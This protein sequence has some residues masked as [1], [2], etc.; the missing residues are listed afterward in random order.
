MRKFRL[1]IYIGMAFSLTGL[2]APIAQSHPVAASAPST[3]VSDRASAP[4]VLALALDVMGGP[5]VVERVSVIKTE[6]SRLTYHLADSEHSL[7]PYIPDYGIVTQW[8]Q[9][10]I[11]AFRSESAIA[12]ATGDGAPLRRSPERATPFRNPHL[13]ASHP[14]S[15]SAPNLRDGSCRIRCLCFWPPPGI[16]T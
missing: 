4:E 16:P 12:A 1:V 10:S 15:T 14:P 7:E 11:P 2:G 13:M 5:D 6:K 9:I 8:I 3:V